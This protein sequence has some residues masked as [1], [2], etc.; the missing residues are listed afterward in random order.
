MHFDRLLIRYKQFGGL[1]LVREY[2]RL[3]LLWPIV[4][5]F[6]TCLF[7]GRSYKQ[8]YSVIGEV[9]TPL[10][11]EKYRGV[12]ED[13]YRSSAESSQGV[14]SPSAP[15]RIWFCWLQGME[16]APDLVKACLNSL[17]KLESG[18]VGCELVI[19]TNDNYKQWV[20]LPDY[21]EEKYRKG[22]IPHVL[23]SDI[24]RLELLTTHGGVWV[25]ST[26][27]YTGERTVPMR[28]G[29]PT[30]IP[31]WKTITESGLFIF[32][33]TPPGHPW[34]GDISNWFIAAKPNNR[35]LS[36]VKSMIFA[37]WKDYDCTLHYYMFHIFFK[38]IS[39][40]Y[41]ELIEKM[42]YG[43]SVPCL[44]LG[45]HIEEDFDEEQWQR[46]SHTIPW[47]KMTYRLSQKVK[48]NKNNY[49]NH[50]VKG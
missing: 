40:Q 37:Y 30:V 25:D 38:A 17:R 27:L 49:Y 14:A 39:L 12:M 15:T 36:I 41:P 9:V 10:L 8:I 23:F 48:D 47:H 20:T 2:V 29:E 13:S 35:M 19:L 43:Y 34:T 6:F 42:P 11:I 26:V 32:Q 18:D 28:E 5:Q 3:G 44:Q 50:I 1:R 31:S 7:T 45:S 46:F 21:I 16:Q 33:Y 24:L 4:K 22:Y